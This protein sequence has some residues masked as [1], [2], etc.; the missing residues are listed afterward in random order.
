MNDLMQLEPEEHVDSELPDLEAYAADLLLIS[1]DDATA[2]ADTLSHIDARITAIKNW[3]LEPKAA[4]NRAH[5][6]ICERERT[7]L[8]K[9]GGPRSTIAAKL[10]DW[11]RAEQA[12][13]EAARQAAEAER[14]RLE[15]D[16]RL[17]AAVIAEANGDLERAERLLTDVVPAIPVPT[18][19]TPV[20]QK[21]QGVGFVQKLKAEVVNRREFARAIADGLLPEDCLEWNQAALDG[22]LRRL[23]AGHAFP[24]GCGIEVKPVTMVR[25]R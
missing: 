4:A 19:S 25:R 1:H 10:V 9:Y 16:L 22:R 6:I 14:Q 17:K 15:D 23:G 5:K 2:A 13:Q 11:H 12:A 24:R 21:V 20:P 7:V 18:L 8:E 3:F